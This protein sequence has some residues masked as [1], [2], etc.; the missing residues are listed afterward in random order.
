MVLAW[1][2]VTASLRNRTSVSNFSHLVAEFTLV[3]KPVIG[4]ITQKD[5]FNSTGAIISPDRRAVLQAVLPQQEN[6]CVELFPIL[7]ECM[8][9]LQ[10]VNELQAK[11]A[12]AETAL[13]DSKSSQKVKD[14]AKHMAKVS[15]MKGGF[16]DRSELTASCLPR[17][18]KDTAKHGQG[19]LHDCVM[20]AVV[21]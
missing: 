1:A 4:E 9:S 17:M 2:S 20:Q 18:V 19:E 21:I 7:L 13:A 11:L 3:S 8:H 6:C 15:C 5:H 16:S 12:Q 14:A 10:Q